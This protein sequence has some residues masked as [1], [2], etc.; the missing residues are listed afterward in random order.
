MLSRAKEHIQ[1]NEQINPKE[2]IGEVVKTYQQDASKN[3]ISI[4]QEDGENIIMQGNAS[5]IKR[6]VEN[7]VENAVLYN[8]D[9]G[10]V[11]ISLKSTKSSASITITDTG[12][13]MNEEDRSKST[14]RL[15]RAEQSRSRV[16]GGS[17]LGLSIVQEIC[18]VHNGTLEIASVQDKGT[19]VTLTFPI[20][21][22][23]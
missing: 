23:S 21:N 10:T 18:T 14:D 9:E 6:A 1:K 17:G 3:N 8:V 12:I 11:T 5:L 13:G 7:I 15:Y 20:H 4:K 2:L 16:H 19:S 22:A